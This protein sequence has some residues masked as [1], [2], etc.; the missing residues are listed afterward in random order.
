MP[1]MSIASWSAKCELP[2]TALRSWSSIS[3]NPPSLQS[4]L[5]DA[6]CTSSMPC[7][8]LI[9]K[10]IELEFDLTSSTSW[11]TVRSSLVVISSRITES[12]VALRACDSAAAAFFV[13][14]PPSAKPCHSKSSTSLTAST[15]PSSSNPPTRFS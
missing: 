1:G 14:S 2:R 13:S 8:Q 11:N 12:A 5:V 6:L 3:A 7:S 10:E 9:C 4:M 15:V